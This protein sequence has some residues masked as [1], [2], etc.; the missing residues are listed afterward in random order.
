MKFTRWLWRSLA[1]PFSL[2]LSLSG[3]TLRSII[4]VQISRIFDPLET[5]LFT[6]PDFFTEKCKKIHFA[7]RILVKN[8]KK[9]GSIIEGLEIL[10]TSIFG[11]IIEGFNVKKS[12]EKKLNVDF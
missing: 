4:G 9:S 8:C 7:K 3:W 5:L 1:F 10:T 2:F 11:S 12:R 6:E